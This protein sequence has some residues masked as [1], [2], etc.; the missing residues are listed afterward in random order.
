MLC[1][2]WYFKDIGF[3]FKPHVCSKRHNV[4]MTAYQLKT[5][6]IVNVKGAD[7]R[8]ILW[9]INRDEAVNRYCSQ[10]SQC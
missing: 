1:H 5:I 7:F 8:F 3:K 10:C 2:D 9:G 4:L 6:A